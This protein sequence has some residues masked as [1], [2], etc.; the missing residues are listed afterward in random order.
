MGQ[1]S[2]ASGFYFRRTPFILLKEAINSGVG[3][4]GICT[5]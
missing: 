5:P 1:N 3:D 4:P 2:A